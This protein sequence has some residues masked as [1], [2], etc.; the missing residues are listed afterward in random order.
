MDIKN[1]YWPAPLAH[2]AKPLLES[3][4]ERVIVGEITSDPANGFK[5]NRFL[6][7]AL[8]PKEDADS[9]LNAIG[10][11][12]SDVKVAIPGRAVGQK[13]SDSPEFW[14]GLLTEQS[15]FESLINKW[16]NH[17]TLV[18]LPDNAFLSCYRLVPELLKDGSMSWHDFDRPVYDVV[19][20]KPASRFVP[21]HGYTRASVTVLRDYLEDYLSLKSCVAIAAYFDERFSTDDPE[22]AALIANGEFSF[23]QAGRTMW[24]KPLKTD[25]CNQVSQVS[26]SAV[27]LIPHSKPITSP[28]EP[29]L[30]WPDHDGPITGDGSGQFD[31]MERA[32]ARDEVLLAYEKR[33]EFEINPESG[34]IRYEHR[35]G[36]GFC[37]RYGRGH[38]V[39]E[40]RKLY[41]GA[42]D[43]II[44][45][46]NAFAVSSEVANKNS[47]VYG[48]RN[49]GVRAKEFVEAFLQVTETLSWLSNGL[50]LVFAQE[51][52][53]QFNTK[54]VKYRGWWTF[55]TFKPIGY[56]IPL[57]M[58][59]PEFLARCKDLFNVLDC[60]RKSPMLQ[61][62][63]KLGLEKKKV[64][65]FE[66]LKLLSTMCQ[67]SKMA[68]EHGQ[69]L[70]ENSSHSAAMWDA[71]TIIDDLSPLFAL[72]GLRIASAHNLLDD[73]VKK[74]LDVFEIDEA[75]CHDGWGL[76][77][78]RVY[79]QVISSLQSLNR[80]IVKAWNGGS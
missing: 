65:S 29:T 73:Q 13:R 17:N 2:C 68:I 61:T 51:D 72:N 38:I 32:F 37:E 18:V 60:L 43:D 24:F 3:S 4:D 70:L 21:I 25:F 11:L 1:D 67:L 47:L 76:A 22:V 6:Y 64:S 19:R 66:S 31:T 58:S 46:Y 40:L 80:Q 53:C 35:W 10:G 27:L 63:L 28:V 14:I 62:V 36:V 77:L 75:A 34:S 56:I 33:P 74:A 12:S 71:K 45:H 48:S 9:V 7:T 52:I 8:V 69:T 39:L 44:K 20:V 30:I 16:D 59:F 26:G 54:D 50:D 78:D 5:G 79:D 41:E 49:V 57:E 23:R 42:P 55:A 15:R